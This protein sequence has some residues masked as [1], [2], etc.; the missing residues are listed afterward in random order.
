MNLTDSMTKIN[1]MRAFAGEGQAQAR[2]LSAADTARQQ[3][4]A[5]IERLFRFTANQEQQHAEIFLR[6]LGECAGENIDIAA[7]FP[8]DSFTDIGSL[9][10][11]AAR[12][13]DSEAHSIYPA[14]AQT[15]Q[16]EGFAITAAKFRAIAE[17]EE[18][19]R[20]RFEHYAMLWREDMLFRSDSTEQ[21]WLCLNCG[22]IHTG[23][24]P[25]AECPVCAVP[26]GYFIRYSE[27]AFTV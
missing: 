18:V 3:K 10:E 15:A 17:I 23:S 2:Y 24:E 21:R 8:A 1:L 22:H 19:H 12:G 4:L 27:A 7:G 14:F 9:L 11:A 6:L 13:E 25:P 20:Q 16:D 26:Q 5:V